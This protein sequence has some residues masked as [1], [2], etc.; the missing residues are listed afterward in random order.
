[1]HS[2]TT[3]A[4][5]PAAARGAVP[6]DEAGRRSAGGH[7]G[8]RQ[9]VITA[10][11]RPLMP[12]GTEPRTAAVASHPRST[13][14]APDRR[15]PVIAAGGEFGVVRSNSSVRASRPGRDDVLR[16]TMTIE[17]SPST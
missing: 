5:E 4:E 17:I 11:P 6:I 12:P 10:P 1:M 9:H 8:R 7:D 15:A 13:N 3:M 16:H 2:D 14:A